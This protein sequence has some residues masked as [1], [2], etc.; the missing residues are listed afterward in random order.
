MKKLW[1]ALG[2]ATL[3][4]AAIPVQF[5]RDEQSGKKTFR[6]LLWKLD[7]GP[8]SHDGEN[9]EISLD[10]MEGILTAPL[11]NAVAAKQEAELFTDDPSE[12]VVVTDSDDAA[13]T[14]NEPAAFVADSADFDADSTDFADD[15]PPAPPADPSEE[16]EDDYFDPEL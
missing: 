2:L 4:A 7:V 12:A 16:T 1:K 14:D 3:A 15:D 13:P 11:L 9:T 10:L 5:K 8:S 6:S